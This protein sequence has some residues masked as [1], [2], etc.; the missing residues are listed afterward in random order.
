MDFVNVGIC[1]VFATLAAQCD[2][3]LVT[4]YQWKI[5]DYRYESSVQ[6]QEDLADQTFIPENVVPVGI[7]VHENR[8]FVTLPRLLNGIPASLATVDIMGKERQIIF[9]SVW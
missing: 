1:I 7:D 9:R 8:M 2:G 5:M 6:R 3:D 4:K